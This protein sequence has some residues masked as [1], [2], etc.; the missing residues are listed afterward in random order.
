[1]YYV[2]LTN[3]VNLRG[4]FVSVGELRSVSLNPQQEYYRSVYTY[5]EDMIKYYEETK[6]I[7]QFRGNVYPDFIPIDL[8]Y[9]K[10]REKP[11]QHLLSLIIYLKDDL[12]LSEEE[13]KVYFSG[14]G[15]HI[16]LAASLFGFTS[17]E[18]L[19]SIV[20]HTMSALLSNFP[21]DPSIYDATRLFRLNGSLNAKSNLYKIQLEP[22]EYLHIASYEKIQELA[23][24]PRVTK[25][26]LEF[27]EFFEPKLLNY[28]V[29]PK[30]KIQKISSEPKKYHCI[31]NMLDNPPVEGERHAYMLR[32]V[33]HFR[34]HH[35]PSELVRAM[36]VGWLGEHYGERSGQVSSSE[37]D[38]IIND[39]YSKNY[40]YSCQDH[41]M[42][43]KCNPNCVL[44]QEIRVYD[45]VDM[46][47][48]TYKFATTD[49]QT[50]NL[51][52]I[53]EDYTAYPGSVIQLVSGTNSGKSAFTQNWVKHMKDVPVLYM[54]FEMPA[55][56]IYRRQMQIE[57]GISKI[58]ALEKMKKHGSKY[59][60]EKYP[61]L[62]MIQRKIGMDD[63]ERVMD[64]L[65]ID[66]FVI[67]IDHLL[68][69]KSERWDEYGKIAE[70]TAAF[71]DFAMQN[72]KIFISI[73]QVSRAASKQDILD[74][75]SA[76]GNS[77]IE[78]DADTLI[79]LQRNDRKSPLAHL[80]I[81]KDREGQFFEKTLGFN[82]ST[83]QF[84][85]IRN[86]K[87]LKAAQLE[88][89]SDEQKLEKLREANSKD[90]RDRKNPFERS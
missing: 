47:H 48:E 90:A 69:M 51:K 29:Q 46:A 54:S 83:L 42:A 24:E 79:L 6:S 62:M 30:P 31:I 88:F 45:A 77:S 74:L 58:A 38:T 87:L 52:W 33:S 15:F 23:K 49:H 89:P 80:Q 63:L 25:A 4:N 67:V 57:E 35:Y 76:K 20:K 60:A 13:F 27:S 14:R 78:A 68:L 18:Y 36:I 53:E 16:A 43:G 85:V 71:K 26:D 40:T 70:L 39:Q 10:I 1:M 32:I 56:Q 86:A 72:R 9:D 50:I 73:S 22:H 7:A 19:P 65:A 17:S 28:V 41:I 34:R 21:F 84:G 82:G 64:G 59:M 3:H 2:E 44:Y 5:G 37:I 11:M 75:H 12:D 55:E 66:P 8:D 61:N 81:A